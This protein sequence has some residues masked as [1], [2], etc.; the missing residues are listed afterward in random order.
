MSDPATQIRKVQAAHAG[1]RQQDIGSFQTLTPQLTALA[2]AL[3]ETYQSSVATPVTS[4]I[5]KLRA[6]GALT[7][8][9][10]KVVEGF[11][12]SSPR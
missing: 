12:M 10:I 3:R 7:P 8:D 11:M 4:V 2:N 1:A 5:M 9:D 6:G